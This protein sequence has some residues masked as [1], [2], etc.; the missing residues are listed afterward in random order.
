MSAAAHFRRLPALTAL[1]VAALALTGAARAAEVIH[2]F[3]SHVVVARDGEL[4]VTETI[5]VRA[6]GAEIR[7]GIYRDFPLTFRDAGGKLH[8]VGFSLV[9]VTRD[10]KDRAVSHRAQRRRVAHLCRRQEHDHCARRPHLRAALP[11]LAPDPLVRRQAR[12]Q[13]E[14]HRQFLALPDFGRELRLE[15][16]AEA[17]PVRWTAFTGRLGA[18]GIDWEGE[19]GRLGS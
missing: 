10:G 1:A 18:R 6:E 9:G 7:R 17:R 4:T 13:L 3:D 12:A 11:Q 5:R 15:L 14:R 16:P 19:V 2:S 8:E